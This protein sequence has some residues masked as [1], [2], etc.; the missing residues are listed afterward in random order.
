MNRN[1]KFEPLRSRL[2]AFVSERDWEQFHTP[3]NL[4]VSISIEASELLEHFQWKEE[5]IQD[6]AWITGV[7]EESADILMYLLLL[8][9]RLGFD[10]LDVASQKLDKNAEK[11]PVV[12]S[13]GTSTK[14]NKLNVGRLKNE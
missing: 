4:A 7:K 11:Y 2:K 10:L 3:R 1:E 13:K 9:E 12:L 6:E 5:P 8:S 14:Y